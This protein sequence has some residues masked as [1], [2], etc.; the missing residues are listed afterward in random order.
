MK[1][2]ILILTATLLIYEYSYPGIYNSG[3]PPGYYNKDPRIGFYITGINKPVE[4]IEEDT[5]E[6]ILNEK[7]KITD[8]VKTMSTREL[9]D[10]YSNTLQSLAENPE[11]IE[12]AENYIL[13]A[14]EI[15]RRKLIVEQTIKDAYEKMKGETGFIDPAKYNDLKEIKRN[16]RL[17]FFLSYSQTEIAEL[18]RFAE[19]LITFFLDN[20]FKIFIVVPSFSEKTDIPEDVINRVPDIIVDNDGKIAS[21]FGVVNFPACSGFVVKDGSVIRLYEGKDYAD[22]IENNLMRQYKIYL[23][24]SKSFKKVDLMK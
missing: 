8:M 17:G 10:A 21:E 14:S 16:V 4:L 11:S 3:Y 12:N 1:T 23:A 15:A 13:Y 24:G 2:I 7:S 9:K 18:S 6:V 22:N 20:G 19:A 5:N